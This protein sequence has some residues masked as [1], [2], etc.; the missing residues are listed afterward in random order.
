MSIARTTLATVAA[1]LVALTA[2]VTPAAASQP[3]HY[4]PTLC[5]T[6]TVTRGWWV[7]TYIGHTE[8]WRNGRRVHVHHYRHQTRPIG[9]SRH[10]TAVD[11]TWARGHR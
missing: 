11:C 7:S 8:E 9:L 3:S 1:T 4:M 6:G 2:T 10:Y 5:G